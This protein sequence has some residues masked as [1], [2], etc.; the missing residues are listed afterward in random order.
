MLRRWFLIQICLDATSELEPN[1]LATS[2]YYA[3]FLAKHKDDATLSD[4]HSRWWPDWYRYTTDSVSGNIIFGDRILFRPNISPDP[5]EYIQ[6]ADTVSLAESS[7]L[8]VGPFDFE[9]ISQTNRTR[10]KVHQTYW[11]R[12]VEICTDKNIIPPTLGSPLRF[13]AQPH[14]TTQTKG[15]KRRR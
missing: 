7:T 1:Y 5:S 13:N 11:K 9:E 8:L 6:W 2:R 14:T 10:C 3:Y 15:T 4:E 12:A